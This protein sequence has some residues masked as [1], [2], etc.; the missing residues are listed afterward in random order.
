MKSGVQTHVHGNY[1]E[2]MEKKYSVTFARRGL[3]YPE[4]VK[5]ANLQANL[6]DWTAVRHEAISSNLL[7]T[8]TVSTSK[9]VCS[10]V[11][12]RLRTLTKT[13]FEFFLAARPDEQRYVLWLALCKKY[14]LI[15]EFAVEVLRERHLHGVPELSTTDYDQFFNRKAEWREELSSLS[16]STERKVRET[17]FLLMRESN[18]LSRKNQI[19]PALLSSRFVQI[20]SA[21]SNE[22]LL[23]YPMHAYPATNAEARAL[24]K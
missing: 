10:E 7:Q 6:E 24:A 11:V 20:V 17:I 4:S 22:L 1:P 5:L 18:L 3:L 16:P 8:R 21:D 13:E 19:I 23:I 9:K 2:L 14:K 12:S 15:F